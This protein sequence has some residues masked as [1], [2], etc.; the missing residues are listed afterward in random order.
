MR[1]FMKRVTWTLIVLV[2]TA[3]CV[4]FGPNL[5]VRFFG[6]PDSQWLSEAYTQTLREKNEL[7]VYEMETTG[8]ETVT[9]DAWLLG[10][11]QKVE[12]PYTFG[13]AYTVD[14]KDASVSVEGSE[15]TVSVPAPTAAYPKLTVDEDNM[16]KV[17]WLYPLTPERYAEIQ[18]TV[19]NRLYSEHA[20]NDQHLLEAWD[21]A[22]R[23]L[24]ALFAPL[25]EPGLMTVQYT[26]RIEQKN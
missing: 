21:V 17:D 3:A 6:N 20:G 14:L 10:T 1:K 2:V 19:E 15:I 22:V 23:N 26:V 12:M 4:R 7:V 9:Q 11:V 24:E 5:Y 8:K 16:R 25:T 18:K 13:M